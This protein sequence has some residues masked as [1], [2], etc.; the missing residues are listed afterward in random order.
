M[1]GNDDGTKGSCRRESWDEIG[2]TEEAIWIGMSLSGSFKPSQSSERR[3][4]W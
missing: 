1:V 3:N 4:T 2:P